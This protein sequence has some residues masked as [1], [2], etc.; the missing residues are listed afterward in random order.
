MP[1]ISITL[2][3]SPRQILLSEFLD[4]FRHP[5]L[6]FIPSYIK[7]T[8]HFLHAIDILGNQPEGALL[9]TY[10]VHS[11]YT[12]IHLAKAEWALARMLIRSRPLATQP[13]NE[14]LLKPLRHVF[15]GNIITF[16]EGNKLFLSTN[17]RNEHGFWM[18]TLNCMYFHKRVSHS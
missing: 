8:S 6:T 14:S 17:E 15:E 4:L 7:D 11:L 12:N 3:P 13:S 9:V 2:Q 10:D 16:S 1:A 18:H 5:H